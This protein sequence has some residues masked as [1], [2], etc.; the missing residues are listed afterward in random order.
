MF[1]GPRY[2]TQATNESVSDFTALTYWQI[3]FRVIASNLLCCFA[4]ARW[5][6]KMAVASEERAPPLL[7]MKDYVQSGGTLQSVN[8]KCT[9]S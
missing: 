8:V 2:H 6:G 9:G 7:E 4:C 1:H 5:N 3:T